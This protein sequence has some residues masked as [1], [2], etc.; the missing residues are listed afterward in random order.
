MA[1]AAPRL[2]ELVE[3]MLG[4]PF[5]VRVRAWDGSQAGPP[6]APALVVRHRRALRRLLFK[7][8]ELGLARAWVAGD[9]DVE[10]DLYTALD[11][12]SG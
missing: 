11:L 1:D 10:G 7:P 6:G 5:P 12:V 2:H 3:Q 9:L 8:G 4:A